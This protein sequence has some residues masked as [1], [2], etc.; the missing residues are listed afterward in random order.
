[1]KIGVMNDPGASVY[2]EV[3]AIGRAGFD[4][5]DLTLEGPTFNLDVQRDP[6]LPYAYPVETIRLACFEELERCAKLFSALGAQIMN[7]HP[8]YAAPPRMRDRLVELNIEALRPISQM[9]ADLGLTLVLENYKPPF[10]RVFHFQTII[11]QVPG[12]GLHLDFGH[13]NMGRD[14]AEAFCKHLGPHLAHVHFS[15]NRKTEDHHMPLGVGSVDWGKA[16]AALRATGYDGTIT[17]EV[18]CDNSDVLF[19]YLDISR[20]LVTRLWDA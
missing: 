4:F 3:E 11:Q 2:A 5:V 17:L 8:C 16:V 7:I 12:L 18:F 1:M 13:T 9:T 19:S 15:D 14:P 6:C 10:D 20:R